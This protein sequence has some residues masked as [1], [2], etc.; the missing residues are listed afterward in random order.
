[1]RLI[2]IILFFLTITVS[3]ISGYFLYDKVF[4]FNILLI[5]SLLIFKY[6]KSSKTRERTIIESL[7]TLFLFIVIFYFGL[8]LQLN[9]YMY[10]KP[11]SPKKAN[12]VK[13]QSFNLDSIN[14]RMASFENYFVKDT[15]TKIHFNNDTVPIHI[16]K[17]KT[18][19]KT[20]R[21]LL[22]IAGMHGDETSG[23]KS[24]PLI[25]EEIIDNK[26]ANDWK[27]D[28]I[29]A[30]NPVGLQLNTRFNEDNCDINRDFN[31]LKTKQARAL[32]KLLKK[33]NYDFV[34]D[35]H[36]GSA[37]KGH[38][39][40]TNF[41]ENELQ[42]EIKKNLKEND[43]HLSPQ[44]NNIVKDELYKLEFINIFT[45][46][47][48]TKLMSLIAYTDNRNITFIFSENDSQLK[49]IKKKKIGHLTVFRTIIENEY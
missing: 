14:K 45:K 36:E 44:L 30:L 17:Q 47:N 35:L 12:V 26:H 13:N 21:K 48:I 38:Y 16:L 27:I 4:Y 46:L 33:S 19:D 18:Y 40:M 15:L 11:G 3:L 10:C 43:I 42:P 23:V 32:K 9:F 25:L 49:S 1:M 29:Y 34:L 24:I 20:K 7:I 8:F 28:L 37:Y 2:Y 41:N 39:F 31:M 6:V 22:I 5:L